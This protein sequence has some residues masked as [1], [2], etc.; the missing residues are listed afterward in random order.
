MSFSGVFKKI[1]RT[2]LITDLKIKTGMR[3]RRYTDTL[4]HLKKSMGLKDAI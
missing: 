3:I 2:I 4:Y 1:S